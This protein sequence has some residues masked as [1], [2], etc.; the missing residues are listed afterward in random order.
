[1]VQSPTSRLTLNLV[2]QIDKSN[3]AAREVLK[4]AKEELSRSETDLAQAMSLTIQRGGF[5]LCF[6]FNP[7]PLWLT[8]FTNWQSGYAIHP[9]LG[10]IPGAAAY[11]CCVC[12]NLMSE[13]F[14]SAQYS[15]CKFGR[16]L[17]KDKTRDWRRHGNINKFKP[18]YTCPTCNTQT[19]RQTM[20][21]P[22]HPKS[23]AFP[24]TCQPA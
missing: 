18:D 11:F 2:Q 14:T 21:L 1:M 16:H 20:P 15:E 13:R 7:Q 8:V 24:I 22:P 12:Q 3:V 5:H 9:N 6:N 4:V 19:A 23:L 17:R 10:Q